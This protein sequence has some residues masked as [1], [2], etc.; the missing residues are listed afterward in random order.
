MSAA[1]DYTQAATDA[2]GAAAEREQDFGGWLSGVSEQ[3]A[4]E[5][6]GSQALVAGR[7]GCWEVEHVRCLGAGAEH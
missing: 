6:G 2:I 5:R 3:V 1:T 4:R 7:P